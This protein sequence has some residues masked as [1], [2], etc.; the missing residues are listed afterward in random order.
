MVTMAGWGDATGRWGLC[1]AQLLH[2]LWVLWG[3]AELLACAGG[4]QGPGTSGRQPLPLTL[5]PP[6]CQDPPCSELPA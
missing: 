4:Q 1:T 2:I 3:A 5:P 6:C